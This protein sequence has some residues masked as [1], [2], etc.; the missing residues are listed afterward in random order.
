MFLLMSSHSGQFNIL[1]ALGD[2]M[3]RDFAFSEIMRQI[4]EREH[5]GCAGTLKLGFALA[6]RA[7]VREPSMMPP[8][9]KQVLSIGHADRNKVGE[10]DA[11]FVG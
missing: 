2:H 6:V 3:D 10:I 9:G 8:L 5:D 11:T 4:V 7:P 1:T